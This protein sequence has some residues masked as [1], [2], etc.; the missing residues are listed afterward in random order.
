VPTIEGRESGAGALH[1]GHATA[2][3]RAAHS[4]EA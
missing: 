3:V 2:S 4:P 1:P